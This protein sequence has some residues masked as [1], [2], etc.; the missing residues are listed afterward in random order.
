MKK[1]LS[2][3]FIA[4]LIFLSGCIFF[5][6]INQPSKSLPNDI[7]TISFH[8]TTEGTDPHDSTSPYFGIC[9][10]VGWTILGDSIN[11]NGVY[12]K[13]IYYNDSLSLEQ[14]SVSPSPSGYFW[15]VG[16]G[17]AISTVSGN[18]YADLFIQ[19]D[20]QI[21]LF[22]IDYM[23]GESYNGVNQ[24]RSNNHQIEII[25]NEYSPKRLQ[26]S[27]E[28]NSVLLNWEAPL[29]SSGLIGY[30]IYRDELQ[31]NTSIIIGTNFYDANPVEGIHYYTIAS[32]YNNGNEYMMPYDKSVVYQSIYVSPNGSNANNGS[33][34]SDAL[35]TI[36]YAMSV[37]RAD[38]LQPIS[39]YLAPGYFSPFTNEEQFPITCLSYV[40]LMGSGE[41]LTY[42]YA[43]DQN[44][45]LQFVE[46]QDNT[47][48][49]LT[50]TNGSTGV[51][52]SSSSVNFSNVIM[53]GNAGHGMNCTNSNPILMNVTIENNGGGG[54]NCVNTSVSL[55]NTTIADNNGS[56]INCSHSV[57]DLADVSIAD[58]VANN[59]GGIYSDSSTINLNNVCITN[60]VAAENGG[61]ISCLNNTVMNF[62]NT[63][64]CNIYYNQAIFGND[65][66]SDTLMNVVVDTFTVLN[67]TGFHTYPIE[68][69]TFNISQGM[70]IQA[71]ADLFVSPEGDN[72]NSGLTVNDPLKTIHCALGKILVDSLHPHTINLLDGTYSGSTNGEIFPVLFPDFVSLSGTTDSSVILDAEGQSNVIRIYTNIKS[73]ISDLNIRGGTGGGI[74]CE[75][76]NAIFERLI[77]TENEGGGFRCINSSPVLKNVAIKNNSGSDGLYCSNSSPFLE[78][79]TIANNALSGIYCQDNSSPQLVNITIVENDRSGIYCES[80]CNPTLEDV[81]IKNNRNDSDGGGIY[82]VDYCNLYLE[83]VTIVNNIAQVF[84]GGICSEEYCNLTLEGVIIENNYGLGGGIYCD[85]SSI[86]LVN[87]TIANNSAH[88]YGG[89]WFKHSSGSFENVT[90]ANNISNF[91]CVIGFSSSSVS[92]VNVTIAGNT[93]LVGI[94]YS[95][96]SDLYLINSIL[97]GHYVQ[98]F[99][100][101]DNSTATISYSDIQGGAGGYTGSNG[102][103]YWLEG[104][105]GEDPLFVGAGDYPYTLSSGSPC[106]D[107]GNPEI[108]YNDSEDPNNLGYALW[109]AMGTIR[110]DMGAYG[111]PNA[112]SW[113]IIVT[114]IEDDETE[115]L[116]LPTEFELAQ[117]YP[118][119]FNPSTTIQ[120]AIKERSHV[121]L[122]LYDILG[123]EV[124][125]LVYEEQAAGYYK[126][127]FNARQL[128]SGV[129]IYRIQANDFVETKKMVL[130][131]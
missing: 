123:Q 119:P 22:S 89:I 104:N 101:N 126:V 30:N 78:N 47:T 48:E 62:N 59:G 66:Y 91:L 81:V 100:T 8:A 19:T 131:K 116:Q 69:F 122:K 55:E 56:G 29:N 125:V 50:I 107:A 60:N 71:E 83:N 43:D 118:N 112:A 21:G 77:I 5:Q 129:Y 33:S 13:I 117:N 124:K 20:N 106:I 110:N 42:L 105:I 108:V 96:D 113:N 99:L 11:C 88:T 57:L 14:E 75:S 63:N 79:V 103:V 35:K 39:I 102:T 44:T 72:T 32:Y 18:V 70:I 25:D 115:D 114:G 74:Y 41:D 86:S 1:M 45:V 37:I 94:R 127:N 49:S 7:V 46:A 12:N 34:F 6:N 54:I 27:V 85:G 130:L 98:L 51:Y 128:A 52:C 26:T 28:G 58:N 38:S 109:P 121:E 40:S 111:G 68:N 93:D 67:P 4:S 97:W 76:T 82:C 92:L 17:V 80:Y 10:P 23:L 120:Y 73:T 64:L 2:I 15:W 95:G 61:G 16:N 31:I 87:V 53:S 65:L 90:I 3:I 9:L 84:G 36:S 24:Q